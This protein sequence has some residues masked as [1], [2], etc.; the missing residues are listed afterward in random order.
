MA[1]EALER[2]YNIWFSIKLINIP[3]Y[4]KKLRRRAGQDIGALS[5][6]LKLKVF[7]YKYFYQ[8]AFAI[9]SNVFGYNSLPGSRRPLVLVHKRILVELTF[10]RALCRQ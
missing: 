4:T 7:L 9:A 2:E 5:N 6:P 8:N 10:E 3:G 1:C